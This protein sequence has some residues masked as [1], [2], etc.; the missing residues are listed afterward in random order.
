MIVTSSA[1][2]QHVRVS[3][4]KTN[5]DGLEYNHKISPDM[6]KVSQVSPTRNLGSSVQY[7][8]YYT[9]VCRT[10]DWG[11]GYEGHD[12]DLYDWTSKDRCEEI[13]T[14][15][16]SC[17]GFEWNELKQCE[18]WKKSNDKNVDKNTP[19]SR[20]H[21]SRCF[22]KKEEEYKII[23]DRRC[24]TDSGRTGSDRKEYFMH[25]YEDYHWSKTDCKDC[26]SDSDWCTGFE[27]N[28][29]GNCEIWFYDSDKFEVSNDKVNG[30]YCYWKN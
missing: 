25:E 16:S 10:D 1:A 11:K 26:C 5:N 30:A 14:D 3:T 13:C 8:K 9:S 12:Y 4:A 24:R 23:K 20:E 6:T 19:W 2:G 18:I 28:P 7:D 29:N 17:K 22:W 27:Y 21:N 15:S